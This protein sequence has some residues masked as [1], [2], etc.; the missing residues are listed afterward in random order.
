[1]TLTPKIKTPSIS[2]ILSV[3]PMLKRTDRHCRYFLRLIHPGVLLYS[4]MVT[5]GAILFGSRERHL[6]FDA[7]EHPI[8][9]QLGGSD[10]EHLAQCAEIGEQWGYDEIN[11][12]IG[13][14]SERVQSGLFGA[15]LMKNPDLVA[16]CVYAMQKRVS[17]PVT[18]KTRIGVDE[19]D[20]YE[21]LVSF[22]QKIASVGCQT[23]IIHARK[24]WLKG[25]S[26][27]ENREIP[28]LDYE[29]V[30]QVKQDFP[31]LEI[32]L[33]GG[34]QTSRE[35][36]AQLERVDGVMIGRAVYQHPYLLAEFLE[37]PPS[38][39]EVMK[40]YLAYIERKMV[41]GGRLAGLIQ[42][43]FGL[44]YNQPSGKRW[45]RGLSQLSFQTAQAVEGLLN[46]L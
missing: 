20:S 17:I 45:R 38:R 4:E 6:D 32:I 42:P 8:A 2:R 39:M 29:R 46:S 30:Y 11:L 10:P 12:N 24:A 25:L 36:L 19:L 34:I 1:M 14:P 27:K 13:C 40:E 44:F 5:T 22:I 3:A 7:S 23:F 41:E 37:N 18:V 28:P 33:N 21:H 9:L 26:P 15:C 31:H 43:V 35:A 16:E